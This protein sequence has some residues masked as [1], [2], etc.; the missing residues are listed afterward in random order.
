[1]INQPRRHHFVPQFLL[2]NFADEV[3]KLWFCNLTKARR[4]INHRPPKS[5][6][7]ERDLN[8]I[9]QRNGLI[10]VRLEDWYHQLETDAAP[11]CEKMISS[12][13]DRANL[14]ISVEERAAW[15]L[16]YYAQGKRSPSSLL[17]MGIEDT[18]EADVTRALEEFEKEHRPATAEE[19]KLLADP[20]ALERI[21]HSCRIHVRANCCDEVLNTLWNRGWLFATPQN[22]G[23]EFLVGDFMPVM[24]SGRRGDGLDAEAWMPIHPRIAF[25]VYGLPSFGKKSVELTDA[26]VLKLN[27]EIAQKSDMIGARKKRDLENAITELD[28]LNQI[29]RRVG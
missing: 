19:R 15:I 1:M 17:R 24:M 23:S 22:P 20:R 27:R 21:R 11:I 25:S 16:F 4:T 2:R 28:Q 9:A 10:N 14:P 7:F 5:I 29:L 26:Q 8:S 18:F 12:V 3:G 6:F 13:L